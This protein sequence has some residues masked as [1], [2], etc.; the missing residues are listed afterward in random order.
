M[1]TPFSKTFSRLLTDHGHAQSWTLLATLITLGAWCWWAVR[2]Q[3]TLYEVSSQARVE[4]DSA[5]YP[6]E[7][8]LAG[9][10]VRTNLHVGKV[11]RAGEVLVE[12]DPVSGQLELRQQVTTVQGLEPVLSRLRAQVAAEGQEG[13]EERKATEVAAEEAGNRVR[14]S[15]ATVKYDEAELSRAQ[16]LQH[17]G[18]APQ[19]DVEKAEAELRRQRAATA[20]L[21]SS[22]RRVIQEQ[23]VHDRERDVRVARLSGEIATLQAQRDN[24]NT[25]ID[26]SKYEIERR[27]IRAAIDG[28]IGECAVLRPGAVLQAGEKLASIVPSGQLVAAAQFPARAAFGRIRP[29]QSARLRMD[30]FPWGE[31]GS[32]N[33][34]V[35]QVAQ[36]I[37]DGNVRVEFQFQPKSDFR[38]KLEH[39]MPGTVEVAVERVTPLSL[40]LRTAGQWM[41][42]HK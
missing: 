36:E 21:E 13:I 28:Y 29:G 19:R 22:A 26:R 33:A 20:A 38:G 34:T 12:I 4:L 42:A 1:T 39:G 8:T 2:A 31:F 3:V 17:E 37:R 9:R 18:L 11:V 27:E 24:L 41:A 30:G 32:V 16:K 15:E 10:V 6:V 23:S 35:S 25:G 5:T 40:I 14:E 7:A